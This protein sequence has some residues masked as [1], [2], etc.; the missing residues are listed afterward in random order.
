MCMPVGKK[1]SNT[2]NIPFTSKEVHLNIN[3]RHMYMIIPRKK[4]L[5]AF[6]M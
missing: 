6:E 1:Y 2:K 3:T 5:K 4:N